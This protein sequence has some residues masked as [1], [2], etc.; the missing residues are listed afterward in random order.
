MLNH[1]TLVLGNFHPVLRNLLV[2]LALQGIDLLF[3]DDFLCLLV[4]EV[5]FHHLN[6]IKLL[7]IS[8]RDELSQNVFEVAEVLF[9]SLLKHLAKCFT[10]FVDRHIEKVFLY[11]IEFI[12]CC[13]VVQVLP[14]FDQ[15]NH[16][17]LHCFEAITESE[18]FISKERALLFQLL[19]H[20]EAEVLVRL[21]SE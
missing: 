1:F 3:L 16:F 7:L 13:S 5:Y 17:S 20:H 12:R 9:E 2:N 6:L 8:V 4:Y 21:V 18:V 19:N 11:G 14:E 10:I 15:L